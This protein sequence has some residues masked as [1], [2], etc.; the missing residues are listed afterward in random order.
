MKRAIEKSQFAENDPARPTVRNDP[1]HREQQ[2]VVVRCQFD[3]AAAC[4]RT[5]LEIEWASGLQL[6]HCLQLTVGRPCA[7]QIVDGELKVGF[8]R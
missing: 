5:L 8:G 2:S 6:T 4:E 1:V 7:L 3:E